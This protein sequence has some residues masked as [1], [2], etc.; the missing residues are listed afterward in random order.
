LAVCPDKWEKYG[1]EV[2]QYAGRA[3]QRRFGDHIQICTLQESCF[4]P[5]SFDVITM[6]ETINHVTDP[7][8][9]L[10]NCRKLLKT[11]GVLALNVGDA[12][13]WM[14]HLMGRYWYQVTPPV[15]IHY[16]TPGTMK[17]VLEKTGFRLLSIDY[18]GKYASIAAS[19]ERFKD[20]TGGAWMKRVCRR[21]ASLP[22]AKKTFYVNLRD[23]MLVFACK[24]A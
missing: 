16:F 20:T 6:W 19:L 1:V 3:A 14:A 4:E 11:G 22:L 23:T 24:R 21:I 15:H 13:S 18:A 8:G 2:S 17:Y 12:S 9:I 7:L 10:K 5:E